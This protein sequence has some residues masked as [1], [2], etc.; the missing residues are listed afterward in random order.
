MTGESTCRH[1]DTSAGAPPWRP[2]GR[3][4]RHVAPFARRRHDGCGTSAAPADA[5]PRALSACR[6]RRGV[7]AGQG[8]ASGNAPCPA[9]PV[10]TRLAPPRPRGHVDMST[11]RHG[12][13]CRSP[14]LVAPP[15]RRRTRPHRPGPSRGG[16]DMP[17]CRIAHVEAQRGG[18]WGSAPCATRCV[19]ARL[20]PPAHIAMPS[21]RHVD[22]GPRIAPSGLAVTVRPRAHPGPHLPLHRGIDMSTCQIAYV[23]AQRG[24][25]RAACALPHA[26]RPVAPHFARG[27]ISRW[28]HA[29]TAIWVRA[30]PATSPDRHLPAGLPGH[31]APD[32]CGAASTCRHDDVM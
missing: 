15:D 9:R 3:G 29:G 7:E 2:R 32:H 10:P 5:N 24:A 27:S 19:P 26:A 4:R 21:C 20:A 25:D 16:V 17:T 28:R 1:V 14:R 13:A 6:R 30:S 11:R 12:S 22:M 31:T 18:T 23:E 8:A